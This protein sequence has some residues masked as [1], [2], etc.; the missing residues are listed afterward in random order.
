MYKP[1]LVEK[2]T[3]EKKKTPC[4]DVSIVISQYSCL[5]AMVLGWKKIKAKPS[6]LF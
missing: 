3:N 4:R 6:R 2:K 1:P 5:E